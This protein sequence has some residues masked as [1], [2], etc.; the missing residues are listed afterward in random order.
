MNP[1]WWLMMIRL[2]RP[3]T[4]LPLYMTLPSAAA[5]TGSPEAPPMSTPLVLLL[6]VCRIGPLEG[7]PQL[8][9]LASEAR[10]G[11]G[12]GGGVSTGG[13]A[14]GVSAGGSRGTGLESVEGTGGWVTGGGLAVALPDS[15]S[16]CPTAS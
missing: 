1:F 9:R 3:R 15:L 4:P 8:I 2:P 16:T 7:Q 13:V 6:N 11:V 12:T 14:G 5:A 10:G